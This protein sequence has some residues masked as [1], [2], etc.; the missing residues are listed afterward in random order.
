MRVRISQLFSFLGAE[1][2][3][4]PLDCLWFPD[5]RDGCE[6]HIVRLLK[7]TRPLEED[8]RYGKEQDREVLQQLGSDNPISLNDVNLVFGN[9]SFYVISF[10]FCDLWFCM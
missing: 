7:E 10:L 3:L 9:D 8:W 5:P 1:L 4:Q 6:N 2:Q